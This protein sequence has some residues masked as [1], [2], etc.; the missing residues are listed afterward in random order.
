MLLVL[1]LLPASP[2]PGIGWA[3]NKKMVEERTKEL[4][5]LNKQAVRQLPN[6]PRDGSI[7]LK[8][9][10]TYEEGEIRFDAVEHQV[11]VQD[12]K[13]DPNAEEQKPAAQVEEKKIEF[14]DPVDHQGAEG[15]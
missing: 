4:D 5:E 10:V 14:G 6:L 8:S 11:T 9:N 15:R 7:E 13:D 12:G 3:G 1:L 2:L